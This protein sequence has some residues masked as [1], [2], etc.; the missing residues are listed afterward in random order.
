MMTNTMPRF[1]Y[2]KLDPNEYNFR[3]WTDKVTDV[4]QGTSCE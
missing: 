4:V 1:V 3:L 2:S